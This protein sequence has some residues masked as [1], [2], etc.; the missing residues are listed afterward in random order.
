M[1]SFFRISLGASPIIPD[2]N[3]SG[4]LQKEFERQL[5]KFN[6]LPEPVAPS[7]IEKVQEEPQGQVT[8][9]VKGFRFEGAN[10]ISDEQLQS[11]LQPWVGQKVSLKELQK[12][13]DQIAE[14]YRKQH[15]LVQT[16]IPPQDLQQ[17]DAIILIKILEAKLGAIRIDPDQKSR[18]KQDLIKNY[19]LFDSQLGEYFYTNRIER[20]LYLLNELPGVAI[21]S[22]I[23]PGDNDG[24]VALRLKFG[25]KP[26]ISG[27]GTLSNYGGNST[28]VMQGLVNL[29]INNPTGYGDQVNLTTITS[30]GSQYGQV[31]YSIPLGASGLKGGMTLSSLYYS[32]IG[33]FAGSQGSS[34]N[35]GI[36][37]SY[38]MLRT[39]STNA[40]LSF[41]YLNKSNFNYNLTTASLVSDYVINEYTFGISGNHY[42]SLWIGG[43]T[44]ASI[45][46]VSG[47]F[48][49]LPDSAGL[50]YGQFTAPTFT[51]LTFSVTRNQQI[52][53]DKMILNLNFNGQVAS[54]NLDGVERF[55]LGGANGVRAYPTSQGSG[56]Q[57]AMLNLDLQYQFPGNVLGYVFYDIGVVNQYKDIN[58]FNAL[59]ANTNAG[60]RYTL[61][62]FGVGAKYSLYG[63][64]L[65]GLIALQLG[66]NPLYRF[67]SSSKSYVPQNNDGTTK[68]LYFWLQANYPF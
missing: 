58:T 6:A 35:W 62:G 55:Y 28:G 13:A 18:I 57:G 54:G 5:P 25:D 19:I 17:E 33:D 43:V 16:N 34:T 12:A 51:K 32:T 59:A 52:I 50:T 23:E 30:L 40:N 4:A 42:D 26:L 38:P 9:V 8:L 47:N 21:E 49:T 53:P 37:L 63:I 67:D 60:N 65:N 48:S 36:N 68:N 3:I 1:L 7:P 22:E 29:N 56:D 31:G 39:Q 45:N 14:M 64:N 66:E 44:N 41:A 10:L 15:L 46:F 11:E 27:Y 20:S 61:S 24:E 2:N